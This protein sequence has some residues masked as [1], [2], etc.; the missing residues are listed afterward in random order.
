MAVFTAAQGSTNQTRQARIAY[1]WVTDLLG[2]SRNDLKNAEGTQI[3]VFGIEIDTK[4]FTA[5]LPDNKL[6]KAVKTTSKVLVKQLVTFLNIQSLVGFL[7]FC[8]QALRLGRVFMRRLW[9]FVNMYPQS[10]TKLTRIRILAWVKEDLEWWNNLLPTYNEVLFFDTSNRQT[11]SLYTNACFY[12]LGGFFFKGK[13]G[14]PT[15]KIHQANAFQAIVYGKS[16]PPNRKMAKNPD[17]PSINAHEIE[18]IILAFQL[19]PPAW[20]RKKVIIYTDSTTAAAGLENSVLRCPANAFLHQILLLAAR[21]DVSIKPQWIEGKKNGLANV[22]SRFDDDKLMTFSLLWQNPLNSMTCPPL[23]YL[24][25]PAQQL[26]NALRYMA[27]L[28]VQK[29]ATARP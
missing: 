27:L 4:S 12:G 6:E 28:P 23:T 9:D 13:G 22:F 18:A 15:A 26:S 21:W 11:I 3:I 7:S 19:W 17:D 5:R 20:H 14:W 2:I 29:R 8:S 1:N 25:H 10:A 16:L 24:P